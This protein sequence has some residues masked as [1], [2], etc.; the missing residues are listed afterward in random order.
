APKPLRAEPLAGSI[1]AILPI[2]K[3]RIAVLHGKQIDLLSDSDGSVVQTLELPE[4]GTCL[5]SD[6]T[7]SWLV[8]GTPRATGPGVAGRARARVAV[9]DGQ[10]KDE[11]EPGDSQKL[12]DG[13]VTVLLFEP[14]E[15]RFFSAGADNKLL[16]TFAR[17]RLEP[18]DKGRGNMHEDVLTA[19][20]WVPG[21]RFVTGSRDATLKSWPPA[22][23][24]Q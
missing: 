5:A 7:G 19:M 18:E 10:D 6:K 1:A 16:T 3:K 11:F 13:A 14:E 12:H 9:F 22:R 17:G 8:A 20:V 23:A 2:S 24:G 21:D 4:D 15:L